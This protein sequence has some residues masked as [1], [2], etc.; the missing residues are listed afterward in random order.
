VTGNTYNVQCYVDEHTRDQ[1][2]T[3]VRLDSRQVGV[4]GN[5]VID[6]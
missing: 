6:E 4:C 3:S 2:S 5:G 1:C